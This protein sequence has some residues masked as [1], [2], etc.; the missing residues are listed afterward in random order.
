MPDGTVEVLTTSWAKDRAV[1]R[2]AEE[3]RD[4]ERA[5]ALKE[6]LAVK[7]EKPPERGPRGRGR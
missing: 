4:R 1:L 3:A 2:A 5:E 7:R 6:H